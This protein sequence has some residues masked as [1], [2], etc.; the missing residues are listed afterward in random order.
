MS[1]GP[2]RMFCF[3]AAFAAVFGAAGQEK[4]PT[5]AYGD[6]RAS[7]GEV[8]FYGV[9]YAVDRGAEWQ[10]VRVYL[11]LT[12]DLLG[13]DAKTG[14]VLWHNSVSA[15]WRRLT[16]VERVER[17][18]PKDK[19][20]KKTWAVE[21]R[22]EDDADG[23]GEHSE[24]YD[25]RTGRQLAVPGR[26]PAGQ[27]LP[28]LRKVNLGH[29]VAKPFRAL[30]STAENFDRLRAR[31]GGP[32]DDRVESE[33][34]APY[35]PGLPA[36]RRP[37]PLPKPAVDFEREVLLAYGLGD[38]VNCF[39]VYVAESYEDDRRIL[40]RMKRST[41]QTS[42]GHFD[43]RNCDVFALPRRAGKAYIVEFDVQSF[44]NSPPVWKEVLHAERLDGT[45]SELAA[46]PPPYKK[47]TPALP[48]GF[49]RKIETFVTKPQETLVV[50]EGRLLELP[51]FGNR[52]EYEYYS[53]PDGKSVPHGKYKESD[54]IGDKWVDVTA[55]ICADGLRDG[56]W[57]FFLPPAGWGEDRQRF[58]IQ[59][60]KGRRDGPFKVWDL[61]DRLR[62]EGAYQGEN[63]QGEWTAYHENGAKAGVHPFQSNLRH[64]TVTRWFA[65]G[66]KAAEGAYDDGV[67]VGEHREWHENGQLKW[68]RRYKKPAEP[69]AAFAQET[70]RVPSAL[71][72]PGDR[73]VEQF[74]GEWLRYG[75]DGKE[76]WRGA[77]KDGT[78][79]FA[80][81]H[82]NGKTYFE[83]VYR[84]NRA[85]GYKEWTAEG[86]LREEQALADDDALRTIE[87]GKRGKRQRETIRE[88]AA[89]IE[90]LPVLAERRTEKLFG[91]NGE[92]VAEGVFLNGAPWSG[93]CYACIEQAWKIGRY[94]NGE[95]DPAVPLRTW[96]KE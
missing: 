40:L 55:G 41:V 52:F 75:P 58:E 64:G 65:D 6:E 77:F 7:T 31:L 95:L 86:L 57:S 73:L 67:P 21:L 54:V 1:T 71:A 53:L 27:R 49:E 89:R 44:I 17:A 62:L 91:P 11:A 45:A 37:L 38:S 46:L 14:N 3:V 19:D 36:G 76:L 56:K 9:S 10:G 25:L 82:P 79:T 12:S 16:F 88:G 26:V 60:A 72:W 51:N 81:F 18:D 48:A 29:A 2:V 34:A 42:G 84:A 70:K 87:Y 85:V 47:E 23:R 78:G 69:W 50:A 30:V 15:Y 22:P 68:L 5:I 20:G 92:A 66:T 32:P 83:T 80:E 35:P 8:T 74:D 61:K 63:A 24:Q 93:D 28:P 43:S 4:P 90:G 59:Y 13:V 33:F 39:G 96:E 94:A